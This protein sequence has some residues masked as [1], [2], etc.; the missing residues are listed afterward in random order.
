V[1]LLTLSSF[2]LFGQLTTENKVERRGFVI[3]LGVGAGVIS[4]SD[5]NQENQF[6]EASGGMTLPNLK[7]GFMLTERLALLAT[8]PGLIY[9]YE[10]HDRS[11]E[12]FIPSLQYWVKDRWWI[13]G[14]FG[15][16]M[17]MPAIY[18][19]K[20]DV[21]DDWNFGCA[22]AFSTGYELVQKRNYT[23]DLQTKLHMGRAFLDNDIHRDGVVLSI[24]LGFNWY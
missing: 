9:E 20:K 22:V 3:G 24:G 7:I 5:S 11:F 12:A 19:I 18:D 16:T 1:L 21:N 17:D 23:L 2:T 14:G 6:D 8:F 4:I 13:N 15:L 10:G